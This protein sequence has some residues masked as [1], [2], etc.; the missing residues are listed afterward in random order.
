MI[1]K[2]RFVTIDTEKFTDGQAAIF[3]ED[4]NSFK[5]SDGS[6]TFNL[7]GDWA[8]AI[9]YGVNDI[10]QND[11][12]SY[13]ATTA[14]TS[15]VDDEPGVGVNWETYWQVWAEKGTDGAAGAPG[16]DGTDGVGVP[17]GGTTGQVLAKIDA[18]NYNTEWV[19]PAPVLAAVYQQS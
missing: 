5:A 6:A 14:H 1:T 7:K 12:G 4:T 11:G 17:A 10:V 8:V 18:T 13:V 16:A 15:T 2:P 19:D 9:D 3:D